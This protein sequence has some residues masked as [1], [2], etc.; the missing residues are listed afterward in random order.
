MPTARSSSP[1][2]P[3]VVFSRGAQVNAQSLIVSAPGITN[4]N[5]MAGRMVFDQPANPN[6]RIVNRGTLTV[7]QAG[8]AAMVAPSVANAGVINARLGRVVLAGA[9]ADTLDLYGDGLVSLDVS[10]QVRQVPAG[11]HGKPVRALV[12]NSGT[13][14]ADGG[15]VQLT[16]AAA[17][18]VI[19]HLVDARGTIRADTVGNRNGAIEIAGTGGSVTIEGN[20]EA[21][22]ASQGGSIAIGTNLTRPLGSG[23]FPTGTSARTRHRRG[24]RTSPPAPET[25]G[26]GGRVTI[27]SIEQTT[28]A[29]TIAARGGASGGAGGTIEL[30]GEHGFALTGRADASAPHGALGS[31][32]LDPTDL[33][34][35]PNT[36]T[37][38]LAPVDGQDP[39]IAYNDGNGPRDRHRSRH[40]GADR[41]R[42]PPGA[43]QSRSRRPAHSDPRRHP[44]ARKPATT[45]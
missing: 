11:P 5:L 23:T 13:I 43:R 32:I 31:I 4:A 40:R 25:R 24:P 30:S 42:S 19:Q 9:A 3:G 38:T 34:I 33:T 35:V 37:T 36:G 28:I 22:G 12:T 1:T 16:A 6:A 45:C 10:S 39:N 27:L 15:T 17:D 8:L 14:A 18:G 7:R 21:D 29:G 44:R 2:R 26:R 20:V 41:Q